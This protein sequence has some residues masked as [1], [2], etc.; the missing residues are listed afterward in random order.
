LTPILKQEILDLIILNSSLEIVGFPLATGTIAAMLHVLTGPDHLA[1]V[2]PLAVEQKNKTWLIGLFWGLGHLAGMLM[3][4][5]LMTLFRTAIPV[6][7]ISEY[8][9]QLV[10]FILIFIGLWS[11]YRIWFNPKTKHQHPHTHNID[12]PITH[13]HEHS[14]SDNDAHMH[15]HTTKTKQQSLWAAF[16]VGTLHGLAGVAHFILFIPTL[17]FESSFDSILY[18][19]GFA[20]GTVLAM[21]IFAFILGEIAHKTELNHNN[22]LFIGIRIS[23]GVFA[24][25]IGLY[26]I[27]NTI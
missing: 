18:L 21:S 5:I 27:L 11:F 7:R 23:T 2:A 10:G 15:E 16:S 22:R 17:S 20:I 8:S 4:G 25:I 3:I 13:I 6:E 19:I 1:A 12:E 26:W 14:H 24:I 9:E